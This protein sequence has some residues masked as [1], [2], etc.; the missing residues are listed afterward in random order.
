MTG[1]TQAS[2]HPCDRVTAGQ[3]LAIRITKSGYIG[4]YVSFKFKTGKVPKGSV[5]CIKLGAKKPSKC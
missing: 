3:T 2:I 5:R 1:V 4:E